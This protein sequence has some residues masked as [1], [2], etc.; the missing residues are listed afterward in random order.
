MTPPLVRLHQD[1]KGAAAVMRLPLRR[2]SWKGISGNFLG[3]GT[4]SSID[5]QDH[6]A[7]QPGDDPR[8]INWQAYARTGHYTM[9]LYRQEVSPRVDLLVDASGSMFLDDDKT[10]RFWELLYFCLESALQ[11][12]ASLRCHALGAG[13]A[14][15][16]PLEQ[17]LAHRWEPPAR[18]PDD[19]AGWEARGL[20]LRHGSLRVVVS[21]LLFPCRAAATLQPL[22]AGGGRG[23]VL[24]PFCDAEAR[25]DWNGNV[26]FEEC[27]SGRLD[28][29]RVEPD[30]LT[31]YDQ[32]YT[33]HFDTWRAE[34]RRHSLLLAR[35]PAAGP[36]L[37]A[38]RAEA[39]PAGAVEL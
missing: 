14:S 34:C 36:F 23:V 38:L 15:P 4:G 33:R 39:L 6:R 29:R 10:R 8:H 21:D 7:Y 20:P 22:C 32:A 31:R 17:L 37:P 1:M 28:T 16:L 5:F 12:G 24:A 25:P 19:A 26:E 9:K 18:A 13:P 27:E 3:A 11:L 35:V 2:G 30:L